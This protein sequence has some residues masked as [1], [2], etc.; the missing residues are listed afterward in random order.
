MMAIEDIAR[1]DDEDC[2][3]FQAGIELAGKRWSASILLAAA[4]GAV[5]YSDYLRMIEGIS[6]RLLALRLKELTQHEL[7]ERR[8]IPTT[9]VQVT[10]SLSPI[11]KELLVSLAPLI[12]WGQKREAEKVLTGVGGKNL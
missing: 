3:K 5:R 7:L 2:R 9:P 10:Y 12:R 8:I 11:G 4:R 1:I 6:E